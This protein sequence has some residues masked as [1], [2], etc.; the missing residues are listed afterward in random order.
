M[1]RDM[2]AE[3]DGLRAEMRELARTVQELARGWIGGVADAERAPAPNPAE[4][5]ESAIAEH[6]RV[7]EAADAGETANGASEP[8]PPVLDAPDLDPRAV[9]LARRAEELGASGLLTHVGYYG[10]GNRAYYWAAD[11]RRAEDVLGQDGERVARV[12]S[13][14]AHRQ[15][16]A[17][18]RAIL[19]GPE[20]AAELVERLG[21]GTTGQFYH[22]LNVL[23]AAD[24]VRQ[25]ERGMFA[26]T[27]HRVPAFLTLLSGVRE[28]L[29]TR[30]SAGSW[31]DATSGEAR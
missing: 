3:I 12:L 29:D 27:N 8:R 6:R 2:A 14:L 22:H 25:E 21:M 10:S 4:E 24:L 13:A 19:Q 11:E 9:H 17:I 1:E 16:L 7:A 26:F 28:L 5:W 23:Q 20:S 15:R 18:L 30:Y 31:G